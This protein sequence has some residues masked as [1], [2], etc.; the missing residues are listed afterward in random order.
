MVLCGILCLLAISIGMGGIDVSNA[1]KHVFTPQIPSADRN[2]KNKVFLEYAD[3]L[4]M[5]E[6]ISPDYQVLYGNVKFRKEGMLMF[7]DSAHFYEKT[8]SFNAFGNV[9]MEQGDTLFVYADVLYYDG[10]EEFARLRNNVRL[11]NR[12]TTLFTDSLD[13]DMRS[14]I[15]YYFDGGRIVDEENELA[16]IYGQYS[17]DTKDAEFLYE[18]TLTNERYVMHT[19]TLHYNTANHIA[20]IVGYTTIVSDSNIIYS[21][22]GWYNT[23]SEDAALYNRSLIVGKDGQ[24]LTGD[25]IFFNRDRNF[26]EVF[27]NMIL[28]DSV[29]S[30]ILEGD[31]GFHDDNK[32]V[33][34]A[35]KRARAME[36]SQKDTLYLHGD[37]IR[38]FL[39]EGPDSL[40]VLTAHHK[41][42]FFRVDMQGVAD[43]VSFTERDTMVR[44]FR[45]PVVWNA[46]RQVFGNVI[47]VHLNDSTVDYAQLPDFGFMIEDIEYP[48]YNQLSGKEMKAYFEN[49]DIRRLDVSGNVLTLFYPMER[50]STYNKLINSESSFMTI[51]FKNRDIEKLN[52]WP[53]VSGKAIPLYLLK[54]KEMYLENFAWYDAV[55]PK[56]KDD[57]FNIPPEMVALMSEPE[58]TTKRDNRRSRKGGGDASAKP[59][60]STIQAPEK[61]ETATDSV[62]SDSIHAGNIIEKIE[63]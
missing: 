46:N 52:M 21:D 28:T 42:R 22:R 29:H 1:Q 23:S 63:K 8:N 33:S 30:S 61:P 51:L 10:I 4:V 12:N 2:V 16:S 26:G 44:M 45:H 49:G 34:F 38:T 18:V 17:P 54:R 48:Y 62:V 59:K 47:E 27:G 3:R 7:C 39:E 41:V 56:D 50:D 35:T 13:Y 24:K 53:D 43:S 9:R 31:Y 60:A 5:D 19:D 11:E 57:I 15:G 20:D 55:R 14:N 36:F 25:T 6:R 32:K 37:T 40:R 58:K